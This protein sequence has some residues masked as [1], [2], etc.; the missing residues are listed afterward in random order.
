MLHSYA[1]TNFQ[2]FRERAEVSLVLNNKTPERGWEQVSPGGQRLSTAVAIMGANG[3]GKTAALKP[4]AFAA[5]FISQSFG[6]APESPIPILPH[7]GAKNE[8]SEIEVESEDATGVA[9][10]YKLRATPQRVLH[11]SLYRK[12]DR[13]GYVFLRDWD[14]AT[15]SY[16]IKQQGF[17]LAATEARKVRPNA[18]LISTAA[19]YGVELA[20]YLLSFRLATNVNVMGRQTFQTGHIRPAT[21]F[22]AENDNLRKQMADLLTKWDL[23]LSDVSVRELEIPASEGKVTKTWVSMGVHKTRDG[24]LVDLPMEQESSG[25][26]SAYVLLSRLLNI[27]SGGGVALMDELESDLHP[28]MVEPVLDLFANPTTNPHRA[29]LIFTCHTPEVLDYLQKSQVIFVEKNECESVAYRGDTID[30]LRSDDNL[31]AKY[32]AGALGAVPRI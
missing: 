15:D 30:G 3:A 8:P 21:Q 17:G 18:S 16:V 14:N 2:S 10:R 6:V 1:F 13:F 5:W 29:Q 25:T 28:H 9:W 4:L 23:G 32:M 26:Q 7:F 19:Q 12:R 31:R 20:S 22:F 11:E 27:L 24:V